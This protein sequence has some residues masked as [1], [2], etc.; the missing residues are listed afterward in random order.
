MPEPSPPPAPGPQANLKDPFV[1]GV[2]AW[3]VPGLGHAY[4]GRYPKAVLLCFTILGTFLYGLYLG[5]DKEV[6]WGR[7]VYFSFRKNDVR[8]YYLCQ[9]GIG[10]PALPALVQADV[11]QRGRR[12]FWHALMA[13][14]KLH[15]NDPP[16]PDPKYPD[17]PAQRT[18][19]EVVH[20]LARLFELGSLYTAIA[21]LLN[22]LAIYDA[23]CGPVLPEP[24]KKKDGQDETEQA[25]PKGQAIPVEKPA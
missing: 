15:A 17:D 19:A 8:L 25:E 23:C 21:G 5:S 4:Q 20:S 16:P 11:V 10:L 14:A 12:P 1:A 9:V 7:V 6:G 18:C 2:L 3:L 22:I 24:A 13:P